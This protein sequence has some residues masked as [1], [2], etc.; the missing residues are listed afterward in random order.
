M[1]N[2][3]AALRIAAKYLRLLSMGASLDCRHAKTVSDA[4]WLALPMKHRLSKQE[5]EEMESIAKSIRLTRLEGSGG[6]R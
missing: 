1:T 2:Q 5:I 3:Q 4:C 6:G